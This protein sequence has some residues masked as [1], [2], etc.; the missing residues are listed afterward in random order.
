M[1]TVDAETHPVFSL[2]HKHLKPDGVPNERRAVVI[3]RPE[4]YDDWLQLND[5]EQARS[6]FGLLPV[7]QLAISA[8]PRA[9]RAKAETVEVGTPA[10][11]FSRLITAPLAVIIAYLASF[12]LV[13]LL[14]IAFAVA[15]HLIRERRRKGK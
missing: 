14:L 13:I 11:L 15:A 1:C 8:A 3:L 2:F 7:D 10:V 12:G 5:P 4:Q 9:P 6:F